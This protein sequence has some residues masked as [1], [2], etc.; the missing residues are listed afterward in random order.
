VNAGQSSVRLGWAGAVRST[1]G[2]NLVNEARVGYSGA[3]VSFFSELNLDMYGGSV[4]NQQGFQLN[5]PTVG[6]QLT[7]PGADA[8]PQS[9]NAYAYLLED[10]LTWLKGAHNITMGGSFTQYDTWAK[11]STLIPKITFGVISVID[12]VGSSAF[13]VLLDHRMHTWHVASLEEIAGIVGRGA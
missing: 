7:S 5:F 4:A 2:R 1:L 9:R 3:P 12:V 11:N 10:T 8:Q 13:R 6:S